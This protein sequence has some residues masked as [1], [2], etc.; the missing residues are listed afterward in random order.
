MAVIDHLTDGDLAARIKVKL[1]AGELPM[2]GP[3]EVFGGPSRGGECCACGERIAAAEA[4]LEVS[5][6]DGVQRVYHPRC[7]VILT[8]ARRASAAGN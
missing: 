4:E 8:R 2:L 6:V 5:A 3:L 7:F 1:A